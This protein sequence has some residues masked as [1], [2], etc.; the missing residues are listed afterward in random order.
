MR[1]PGGLGQGKRQAAATG[2]GEANSLAT[3]ARYHEELRRRKLESRREAWS[4]RDLLDRRQLSQRGDAG[5]A[6]VLL[7]VSTRNLG[8]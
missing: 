7:G 1:Q 4:R 8:N 2:P 3:L 6:E 5:S